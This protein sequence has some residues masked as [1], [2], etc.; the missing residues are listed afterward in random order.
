[1]RGE[2]IVERLLACNPAL[3]AKEFAGRL[4]VYL[5]E[6]PIIP[7]GPMT[8]YPGS[9][10]RGFLERAGVTPEAWYDNSRILS[11]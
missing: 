7:I 11:P 1:M 5:D 4:V 10:L 6:E 8:D 9:R 3:T 2:H